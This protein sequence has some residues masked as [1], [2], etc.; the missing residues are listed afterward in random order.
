MNQSLYLKKTHAIGEITHAQKL[1]DSSPK[2]ELNEIVTYAKTKVL[3][4]N[5]VVPLPYILSSF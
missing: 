3:G 2:F 5:Q 1:T 4:V